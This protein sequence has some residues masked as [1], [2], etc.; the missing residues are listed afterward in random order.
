M[1]RAVLALFGLFLVESGILFAAIIVSAG[2][3]WS[4][5]A[6]VDRLARTCLNPA[7]PCAPGET[8]VQTDDGS[9]AKCVPRPVPPPPTTTLPSPPTPPPPTP[10]PVPTA[11]PPTPGP[12]VTP[13]P[14]HPSPA[15]CPGPAPGPVCAGTDPAGWCG[16]CY[17]CREDG[18]WKQHNKACGPECDTRCRPLPDGSLP[19]R[20]LDKQDYDIRQGHRHKAPPGAPY[21]SYGCLSNGQPELPGCAG[22]NCMDR[23]CNRIDCATGRILAPATDGWYA[24]CDAGPPQPCSP[25]PTPQPPTPGP[26]VTPPPPGAC[27]PI[28]E[29]GGSMLAPRSCA[30]GCVKDGYLGYVVNWTA[31]ELISA[32]TGLCPA[33]RLRCEMPRACQDVRGAYTWL[34]LPGVFEMGICDQRSDNYFNCHHKPKANEVGR[35]FFISCPFGVQPPVPPASDPRCT[36]HVVD[37]RPEGPKEIK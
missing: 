14:P 18:R 9:I 33:G 37:V 30:P 34:Y 3:L 26:I 11:P 24:I 7:N 35:T 12:A 1:K 27:P 19:W 8:C 13:P 28:L 31:T 17:T 36:I 16:G 10:E 6:T 5:C 21:Y 23:A 2:F 22:F 29:V 4:S 32:D 15:G 25:P 20:C